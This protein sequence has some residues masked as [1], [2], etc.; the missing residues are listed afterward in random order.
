MSSVRRRGDSSRVEDYLK[1]IYAFT[2]WQHTP[3]RSTQLAARLK[4]T[5]P[6]ASGM[7]R[8]L[9]DSGLVIHKPYGDIELTPAGRSLALRAVRRHRLV[10]SWLVREL[11]Y[12]W[13]EIRD[14]A[15][16]LEH[17][18]SVTMMER[19]SATLG[20]PS[21]NPHGDPIP[22]ACGTVHLPPAIR[23]D[24]LPPGRQGIILRVSDEDP[25]LLRLLSAKG[26][27]LM[28][29]LMSCTAS[30]PVGP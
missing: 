16:R 27:F 4:V 18:V 8:K 24:Q 20:N 13:D 19:M 1:A 29:Q 23:L 30:P 2:E 7:V 26:S 11:G 22:D 17:A 3:I 10:E 21:R 25:A 9:R 15:E 14:E 28:P 6:S 12:G 5:N